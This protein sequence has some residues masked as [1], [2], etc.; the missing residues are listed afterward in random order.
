MGRE[1]VLAAARAFLVNS[2]AL[3]DACTVTRKTS[4]TT[5]PNT[6]VVTPT[7][8]MALYTGPCRIQAQ[9]ANWA[10]PTDVAEAALRL[11]AFELQLPVVGSAGINIDDRVTITSSVND[12][13]L[14]GRV[15]TITGASRKSHGSTRKLPLLEVL[16]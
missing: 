4:E 1:N 16:S 15:F 3:C 13:D 14:A 8:G 9:S 5:D 12:P 7:Y 11:A 6:G 10:G 2:G